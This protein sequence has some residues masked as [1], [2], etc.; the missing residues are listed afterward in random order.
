MELEGGIFDTIND[1][2]KNNSESLDL[3]IY[4]LDNFPAYFWEKT[5]IHKLV[6]LKSLNLSKTKLQDI[7]SI[8]WRL[9]FLEELDL[10]GNRFSQVSHEIGELEKLKR[11]DLSNGYLSQVPT[12]I[13]S[14]HQLKYLNLC[15]NSFASAVNYQGFDSV[16]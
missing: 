10:S 15:N 3:S 9:R 13:G 5:N 4:S 11:L 12:A 2:L 7:P 14:L 1:A 16:M 8:I 6:S